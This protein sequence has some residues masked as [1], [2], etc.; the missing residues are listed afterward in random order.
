MKETIMIPLILGLV[1]AVL[2]LGLSMSVYGAGVLVE[3]AW[4]A[5]VFFGLIALGFSVYAINRPMP[6]W[7]CRRFEA[8]KP[9]GNVW[10]ASAHCG[11]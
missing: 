1:S 6:A 3:S 11:C 7:L 10:D 4:V 2:F 9:K 5:P 8:G